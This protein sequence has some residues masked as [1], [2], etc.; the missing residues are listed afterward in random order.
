M[1]DPISLAAVAGL[2]FAGRALSTKSEPEPVVQVQ[3]V[4]Q[5]PEALDAV[6]EFI[7]RDFE[8]R[9][10]NSPK[11]GDGEFRRHWSPTE[12]WW[13]GDPQYEKPYV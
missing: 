11:D 10:G 9:V 2:I 8:P 3:Q 7:E 13:S 1:A 5:T 4:V 6:P 12:K